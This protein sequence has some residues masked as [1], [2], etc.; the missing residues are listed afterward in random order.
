M[1]QI[2]NLYCQENGIEYRE[3]TPYQLRLTKGF[4]TCDVYPVN[5][6]YHIIKHTESEMIQKRGDIGVLNEFLESIFNYG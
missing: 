5:E 1:K 3:L 6:R 4:I 2:I